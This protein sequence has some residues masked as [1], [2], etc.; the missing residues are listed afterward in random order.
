[1]KNK[2][3]KLRHYKTYKFVKEFIQ[4]R[5][6]EIPMVE[7]ND[8]LGAE[9]MQVGLETEYKATLDCHLSERIFALSPQIFDPI[10]TRIFFLQL[11]AYVDGQRAANPKLTR[12]EC[13]SNYL[14]YCGVSEDEVPLRAGIKIYDRYRI[15]R[16]KS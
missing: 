5:Y 10:F 9:I 8:E 16:P 7:L 14:V 11:V 13:I 3:K 4:K 6:G 15:D 1:M 12:T 2:T